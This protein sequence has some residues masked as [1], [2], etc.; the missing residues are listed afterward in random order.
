MSAT[1]V[2]PAREHPRLVPDTFRGTSGAM[3]WRVVYPIRSPR[4]RDK[5]EIKE[6][7]QHTEKK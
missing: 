6:V 1:A 5:K 3:F 4:F 2:A 7:E